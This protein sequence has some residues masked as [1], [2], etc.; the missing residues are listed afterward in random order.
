MWKHV[1]FWPL[2]A[3]TFS[4]KEDGRRRDPSNDDDDDDDG[5]EDEM[6]L[7]VV[8]RHEKQTQ[9]SRRQGSELQ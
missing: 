4:G 5:W 6:E 9:I 3:A 8:Q 2:M 1:T 7:D